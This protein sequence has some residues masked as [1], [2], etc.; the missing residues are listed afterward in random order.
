[1]PRRGSMHG[2][3]DDLHDDECPALETPR[4]AR[5]VLVKSVCRPVVVEDIEE[6]KIRVVYAEWCESCGAADWEVV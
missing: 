2:L 4:S 1:M 6:P 5:G 3:L